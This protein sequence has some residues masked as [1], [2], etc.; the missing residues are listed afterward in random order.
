MTS[1]SGASPLGKEPAPRDA[2]SDGFGGD[3]EN[4]NPTQDAWEEGILNKLYF[5]GFPV[6]LQMLSGSPWL[7]WNFMNNSRHFSQT[8]RFCWDAVILFSVKAE[9]YHI[10]DTR[11]HIPLRSPHICRL[12]HLE[13]LVLSWTGRAYDVCGPDTLTGTPSTCQSLRR[14]PPCSVSPERLTPSP[15]FLDLKLCPTYHL[16]DD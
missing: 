13:S 10:L 2:C 7:F 8:Y 16:K 5:W 14:C 12:C 6:T 9:E 11:K 15:T 3:A 4:I 1:A